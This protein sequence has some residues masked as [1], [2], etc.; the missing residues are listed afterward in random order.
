[1]ANTFFD[2][3]AASNAPPPKG[4][5][6]I[7]A[8][9]GQELQ[10]FL[11]HGVNRAILVEPLPEPFAYI[12]NICKTAPGFIAFN[13]LCADFSNKVYKFHVASNGGMSSS[14]L[15]PKKHLEMFEQVR[16]DQTVE[17]TTTTVDELMAFL[18]LN[19]YGPITDAIDTLYM[20]VQGAE[21]KVLLGAPRT[22]QSINYVTMELIRG[23]LYEG[24]QPLAAYC[25][26]FEAQGFTLNNLN[27]NAHH[28]A[29][30]LFIRKSLL[31]L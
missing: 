29:E 22:L 2:L 12:A 13:G 4:I 9:Y 19:G 20:D 10:Q 27:F 25:A 16:F 24:I 15:A 23:D 28:H 17:I 21:Y 31:N 14:I 26:L 1:M 6:Q 7:G 30:A 3:I 8:S 11:D 5:L 18:K